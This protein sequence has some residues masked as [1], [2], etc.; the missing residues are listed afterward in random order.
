MDLVCFVHL[1]P[2]H[3]CNTISLE[4]ER[5]GFSCWYDQTADKI[6]KQAMAQGVASAE[7]FLLF[8]S[9]NSDGSGTMG[10]E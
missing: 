3:Q 1:D 6:D 5:L 2:T 8:L 9:S 7:C 10:K 4:L